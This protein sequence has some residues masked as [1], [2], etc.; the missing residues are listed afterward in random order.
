MKKL[1]CVICDKY[2]KFE[3]PKMSYLWEK[4][5]VL[6]ITCSKCENEEEELFKE[7]ESNEMLKIPGL[8]E[9]MVEENIS[10]EFKLKNIDE[11]RN[12]SSEEIESRMNW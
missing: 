12:Y 3:K 4:R 9:N 5:L 11:I 10:Q 7:D 2:R 6:F 8:I 1:Y